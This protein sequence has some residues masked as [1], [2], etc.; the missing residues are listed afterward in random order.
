MDIINDLVIGN[1]MGKFDL[2]IGMVIRGIFIRG[3]YS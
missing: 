1:G 2:C 3:A